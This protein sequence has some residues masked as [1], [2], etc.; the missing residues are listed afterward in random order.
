[1]TVNSCDARDAAHLPRGLGAWAD[2]H[3]GVIRAI[4]DFESYPWPDAEEP[5]DNEMFELLG[6][7]LPEGMA[8]AAGTGE[9]YS[10]TASGSW[11]TCPSSGP[12]AG[13]GGWSSWCPTGLAG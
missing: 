12:Y 6:K 3:R 1:M 7:L 4:D 2:E 9:A 11:A 5:L 8:L 13:T 10:S